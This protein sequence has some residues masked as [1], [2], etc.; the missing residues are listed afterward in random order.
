MSLARL[1]TPSA[2]IMSTRRMIGFWL[3]S[4]A[5]AP[6]SSGVSSICW[7]SAPV[8]RPPSSFETRFSP[9]YSSSSR[10]LIRPGEVSSSRTSRPVAKASIFSASMS[11]GLAVAASR[12]ESVIRSG[13]TWCL[14]ATL[15]GTTSRTFMSIVVK[16]ASGRRKRAEMAV[17][18]SSSVMIRRW[19]SCSQSDVGV[20]SAASRMAAMASSGTVISSVGTSHSSR[21]AIPQLAST[22]WNPK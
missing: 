17:R 21:N 2:S 19:T 5:E 16:S 20:A 6:T 11:N 18:I 4:S 14:R 8:S 3:A 1:V 15:S 7:T 13:S 10:S 22:K 12:V 9:R